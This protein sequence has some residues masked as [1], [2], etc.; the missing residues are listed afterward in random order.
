MEDVLS[1]AAN[2][3]A[4]KADITIEEDGESA[5]LMYDGTSSRWRL[6]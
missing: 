2:R 4:I 3:F 1:S 6:I 5:I